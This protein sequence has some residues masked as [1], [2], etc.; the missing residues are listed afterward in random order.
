MMGWWIFAGQVATTFLTVG[1]QKP[2]R[3]IAVITT[4]AAVTAHMDAWSDAIR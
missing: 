1:I 4:D 3:Q 2:G